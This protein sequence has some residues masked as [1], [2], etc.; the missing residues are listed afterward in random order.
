MDIRGLALWDKQ[1]FS[2][3]G[4][5]TNILKS[6]KKTTMRHHKEAR[7]RRINQKP[8][9]RDFDETHNSGLEKQTKA[10]GNHYYYVF[11][12]PL[13]DTSIVTLTKYFAPKF[14]I[15]RV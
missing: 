15:G 2:K 13:Y 11:Y 9:K 14:P 12:I 4:W 7:K 6:Q 8:R 5:A 3:I 1:Y 10:E